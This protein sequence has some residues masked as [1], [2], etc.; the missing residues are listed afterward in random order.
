MKYT[1][2]I[3][4]KAVE[5]ALDGVH[6]KVIQH[7]IGPNPAATMRYLTKAGHNYTEVLASLKER[8]IIPK[9]PERLAKEK[10]EAKAES[11][12]SSTSDAKAI[13]EEDAVENDEDKGLI[14][15]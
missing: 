14:F 11:K 15:E 8:G 9:T 10:A 13:A 4:D 7:T 5:A 6:L 12:K 3:K 2:E 1:Q